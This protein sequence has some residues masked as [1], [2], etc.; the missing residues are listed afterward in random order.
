[1]N[2]GILQNEFLSNFIN[3]RNHY[4]SKLKDLQL[5]VINC[6]VKK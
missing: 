5:I 1:M 2:F 6:K 3:F 4:N